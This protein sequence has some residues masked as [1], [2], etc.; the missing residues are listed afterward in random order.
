MAMRFIP[1]DSLSDAQCEEIA[2]IMTDPDV[3]QNMGG[4]ARLWTRERIFNMRNFARSDARAD[5]RNYFYWAIL[6][7]RAQHII[8]ICG[9]HPAI[10]QMIAYFENDHF[11]KSANPLQIMYAIDR[12]EWGKGY[13]TRA[14][15][16]ICAQPGIRGRQI[17]GLIF[18]DNHASIRAIQKSE[19][20]DRAASANIIVRGRECAIFIA[21]QCHNPR[22]TDM[23]R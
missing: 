15:R 3:A 6:P 22:D 7:S 9:F 2:H 10:P 20:F 14:I 17:W 18:A 21:R 12:D 4:G 5:S 1:F 23:F 11:S 16:G 8:G 19:M 13:A